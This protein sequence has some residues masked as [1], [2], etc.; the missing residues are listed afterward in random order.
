MKKI[1]VI[2]LVIMLG[3]NTQAQIKTAVYWT[4]STITEN[5]VNILARDS[6]L[7]IDVENFNNNPEQIEQIKKLNPSIITLLYINPMEMWDRIIEGR[8]L[9]NK[10]KEEMP[11]QFI[12]KKIDGSPLVFWPNMHMMNMSMHCPRVKEK[13]YI[14]FYAEWLNKQIAQMPTTKGIFID[15]GTSTISWMSDKIDADN[16]GK[17]DLPKALDISW[18][19]GMIEF[20]ALLRKDKAKN[21]IIVSNKADKHLF[22]ANEGVMF[23][24]FPNNYL[25]DTLANGWYR[26]LELAEKSGQ[27]TIFQSEAKDI[28]FVIASSL[29]LD[30]IYVCM[31]QNRSIPREYLLN[32]GKPLAKY[33]E[34]DELQCRDYENYRIEVNPEKQSAK[35]I[36][37]ALK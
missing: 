1:L 11:E 16:D 10:L 9:Q 28:E 18:R 23:E 21:F 12:L 8:E 3:L 22:F 35:F 14:D 2:T 30:N 13:R 4:A 26:C 5:M 37:R 25:G 17:A 7:I 27:F 33:Y 6:L 31:G 15:N 20:I 32:I 24:N 29:L 19:S 36:K 34:K